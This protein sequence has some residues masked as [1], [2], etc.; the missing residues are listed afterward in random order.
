MFILHVIIV[1]LH[2]I[3]VL[4]GLV[5]I[6]FLKGASL[7]HAQMCSSSIPTSV[8]SSIWRTR[9]VTQLRLEKEN[10]T[11]T[12]EALDGERSEAGKEG[13]A[14]HEDEAAASPPAKHGRAQEVVLADEESEREKPEEEIGGGRGGGARGRST[15]RI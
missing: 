7:C 5:C 14:Q 4:K 12:S 8:Q 2:H 13:G 3:R 1:C 9:N 10:T 6:E 11:M 15:S